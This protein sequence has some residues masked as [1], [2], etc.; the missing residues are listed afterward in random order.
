MEWLS[1]VYGKFFLNHTRLS[2]AVVGTLAA[3]IAVPVALGVW[4]RA[5]DKYRA[6][7]PTHSS[8][9]PATIPTPAPAVKEPTPPKTPRSAFRRAPRR[10]SPGGEID[11][12]SG[13]ATTTGDESPAVTGSGNTIVINP[14]PEPKEPRKKPPK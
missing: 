8:P 14:Q 2:Y 12:S 5:I 13:D 3:L 4:A 9:P 6:E 1:W 10:K 7:H 11:W